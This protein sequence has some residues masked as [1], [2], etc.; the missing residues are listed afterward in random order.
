MSDNSKTD[1]TVERAKKLSERDGIPFHKA[2]S[3]V[4]TGKGS[5]RSGQKSRRKTRNSKDRDLE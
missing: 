3:Y 5:D 4:L 2:I 1:T